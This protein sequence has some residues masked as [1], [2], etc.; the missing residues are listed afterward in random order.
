[1]STNNAPMV[2]AAARALCNDH[3]EICNVNA[4]DLW[5]LES[6]DFKRMAAVVLD[7]AG[8]PEAINVLTAAKHYVETNRRSLMECHTNPGTGELDE[9]GEQGVAEDGALLMWID[10]VIDKAQGKA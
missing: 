7:A 1:M 2:I 5:K 3:A 8:V 10:M 6:E 4:D 9:L